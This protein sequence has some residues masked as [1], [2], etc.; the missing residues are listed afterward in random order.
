M[1][2]ASDFRDNLRQ[3][4]PIERQVLDDE[5]A[6]MRKWLRPLQRYDEAE[7]AL[8]LV[9]KAHDAFRKGRLA[10]AR[11]RLGRTER[12]LQG[13][14]KPCYGRVLGIPTE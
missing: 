3:E 14:L 10:E 1:N 7:K 9:G 2:H 8:V 4:V 13:L 11:T 12:E 5:F 6:S